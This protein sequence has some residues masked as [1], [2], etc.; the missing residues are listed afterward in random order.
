[1]GLGDGSVGKV[2]PMQGEGLKEN[3]GMLRAHDL[4]GGAEDP[5]AL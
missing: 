3:L 5:G 1:M 4:N 2:L